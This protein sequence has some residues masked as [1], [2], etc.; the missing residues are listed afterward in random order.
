MAVELAKVSL[1]LDAFTLGAP[2]SFLDHHLRCG[3]SLIGAT[4]KDLEAAT[5]GQLFRID[6]EPL[7]RA[8]RHVLFV[9]AMADA[10]AA[11]V[12]QSASEY[13]QARRDLAGYQIVLDLLVAR[14]FGFPKAPELLT[15]AQEIDLSSRE[16]FLASLDDLMELS[17]VEK[18]ESLAQQSDR[19]FF[20]WEIEFPEVFFAFADANQRHLK[21]KNEI[22]AG[23]A[24]FDCVVGN[25]P[26]VRQE[27]LKELKP[28]LSQ[29]FD[30]YHSVADHCLF[31]RSR[32]SGRTRRRRCGL[33]P[34]AV[35]CDLFGGPPEVGTGR[36]CRVSSTW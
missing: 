15:R 32:L 5:K 31:L 33:S 10:T 11:E 36:D 6:Y 28:Y 26:Y 12:K 23:T 19:R 9:N 2:L 18:V 29:V 3:N 22:A 1:W 13:G 17:L 25:P 20:H 24:G 4:F 8:I 30:C 7:L 34:A 35:G 27:Q 21:H 16:K 14:H